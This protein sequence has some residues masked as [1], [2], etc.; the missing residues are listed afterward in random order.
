[1]EIII[2]NYSVSESIVVLSTLNVA[3][4]IH[5]VL[6]VV[7]LSTYSC[8]IQEKTHFS[9]KCFFLLPLSS[10]KVTTLSFLL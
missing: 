10:V 3:S 4:D 6:I 2:P 7:C 1:M 5:V 9:L 8:N